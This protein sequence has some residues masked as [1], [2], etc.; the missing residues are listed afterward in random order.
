MTKNEKKLSMV[1]ERV[2]IAKAKLAEI[3]AYT[4]SLVAL[5]KEYEAL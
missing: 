2:A 5:R 1:K 4:A 3:K